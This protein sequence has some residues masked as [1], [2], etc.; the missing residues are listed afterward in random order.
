MYVYTFTA[1][2]YITF[3]LALLSA[4]YMYMFMYMCTRVGRL[5]I[6]NYPMCAFVRYIMVLTC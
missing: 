3:M 5:F 2:D 1:H 6:S 4:I